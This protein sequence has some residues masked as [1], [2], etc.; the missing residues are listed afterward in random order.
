MNS[1]KMI[2][3]QMQKRTWIEGSLTSCFSFINLS[4]NVPISLFHSAFVL[5]SKWKLFWAAITWMS[6]KQQTHGSRIE[7]ERM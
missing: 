2:Q 5:Q 6:K 7:S 4:W 3:Q 1:E